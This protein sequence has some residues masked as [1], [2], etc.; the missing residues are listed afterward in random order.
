[1]KKRT[2]REDGEA[3]E[4]PAQCAAGETEIQPDF[5]SSDPQPGAQRPS[6]PEKLQIITSS[7]H[8]SDINIYIGP[9]IKKTSRWGFGDNVPNP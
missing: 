1:M 8:Q 5:L 2:A 3:G 4:G 6:A 7:L 9:N